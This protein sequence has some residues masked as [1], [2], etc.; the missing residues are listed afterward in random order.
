VILVGGLI[1]VG[2]HK[3]SK[4]DAERIEEHT[5]LPPEELED[6]DLEQAMQ[7][8]SIAPQPLSPEEQSQVAAAGGPDESG[9]GDP[10]AEPAA[11]GA[12]AGS[13][14][15]DELERLAKLHADGILTDEEFEA[16][17]KQILGL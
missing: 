4:R 12:A 10:A 14:Y 1:A 9:A 6:A 11:S 7:E 2:A 8:L 17:K 5:G 13:S 3:F 15:T 16:K